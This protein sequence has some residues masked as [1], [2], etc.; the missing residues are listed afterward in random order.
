M[1][2]KSIVIIGK[3][4]LHV[5]G[6]FFLPL[7]VIL[8]A[9]LI[10]GA[11][12][13]SSTYTM[14]FLISLIFVVPSFLA[15]S[16]SVGIKVARDVQTYAKT[17]LNQRDLTPRIY[18]FDSVGR[19]ATLL[20]TRGWGAMLA[21]AF[22]TIASMQ[23]GWA[24]LGTTATF[25]ILLLY[26]VLG[27]SA[28]VSTFM[29]RSFASSLSRK[30]S[31]IHR[32]VIPAVVLRGDIAE[33]RFVLRRVPVPI[34]F[35]LFIEDKNPL[36]LD[37]VSRYAASSSAQTG[38]VTLRGVFRKT[39][40]GLHKLGPANI[41]YQ[42]AL[43]LT[44][45]SVSSTS[46]TWFKCL[47]NIRPVDI[48]EAPRSNV[49]SPDILCTPHRFPTEDY[50]RFTE[51]HVGDDTRRI[52]WGLSIR[53]GTFQVRKPETKEQ[54]IDSILLVLDSFLPN[55]KAFPDLVEVE[56]ILDALIEVWLSLAVR[57]QEQGHKVSLV[58][59]AD[60]GKG[61]L[62][63]STIH[64]AQQSLMQWQDLGARIRWQDE[65]DVDQLAMTLEE[66]THLIVISSRTVPPPPLPTGRS[67]TW[68]YLPPTDVLV[69]DTRSFWETLVGAGPGFVTRLFKGAL[70]LPY[71]TGTEE[72]T[73]RNQFRK[74][75]WLRKQYN[76]RKLLRLLAKR[77]GEET[78]AAIV[79]Q[80]TA[81]YQLK[82]EAGVYRL[83]GMRG[84]E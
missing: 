15:L 70:F 75:M 72:N 56:E 41:W 71:P 30:N 59:V 23:V 82:Q 48:Q 43:G 8:L 38:I 39:P 62:V 36:V 83:I 80:S 21:G 74:Y 11:S 37:T 79:A 65:M 77:S 49:E 44:K 58:A 63:T 69:H 54:T 1:N 52:H 31:G 3:A 50:F 14:F 46:T 10:F 35:V 51:Y 60:D 45:I 78:Y 55:S 76:M 4:I 81:V 16:I 26:L 66:G 18:F 22:F 67:L 73:M 34:G 19:H 40:R 32:E 24:S 53:T 68:V 29:V 28:L 84:E 33:E 9:S 64:C 20:T 57:L 12:E 47:P 42:D 13:V 5:C 6:V 25:L 61:A 27:I 17:P 2:N 7:A